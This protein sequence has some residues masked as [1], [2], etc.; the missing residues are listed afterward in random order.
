[1][2]ALP[3]PST[4]PASAALAFTFGMGQA[5]FWALTTPAI[6][7]LQGLP[8]LA[9]AF[10]IL[11]LVRQGILMHTIAEVIIWKVNDKNHLDLNFLLDVAGQ[12]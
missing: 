7:E 12:A 9:T 6:V 5:A 11:T 10:G 2:L 4:F 1:V 3:F 8:G